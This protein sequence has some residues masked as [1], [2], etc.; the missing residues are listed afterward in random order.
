MVSLKKNIHKFMYGHSSL[1]IFYMHDYIKYYMVY[2]P[3]APS[4]LREKKNI[5]LTV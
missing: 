4:M 5:I 3:V 1:I 2:I